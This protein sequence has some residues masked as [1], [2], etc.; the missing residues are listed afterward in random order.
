MA[1]LY[2][3]LNLSLNGLIFAYAQQYRMTVEQLEKAVALDPDTSIVHWGL[4]VAYHH[5]NIFNEAIEEFQKARN[6][7]PGSLFPS[8]IWVVRVPL[9]GI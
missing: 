1:E 7:L 6:L 4:G 9:L 5:L 2:D 8:A 3:P